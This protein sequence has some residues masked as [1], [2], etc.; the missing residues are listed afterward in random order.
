MKKLYGLI[1]FMALSC[2]VFS[3]K[4]TLKGPKAKKHKV[5]NDVYQ[6]QQKLY[7]YTSTRPQMKG[8]RAKNYKSQQDKNRNN[9]YPIAVVLKRNQIRNRKQ[10]NLLPGSSRRLN[11]QKVIGKR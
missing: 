5:H 11:R 10:K 8:P 7:L 9:Y 3:Q 6:K 2:F 4:S 1:F